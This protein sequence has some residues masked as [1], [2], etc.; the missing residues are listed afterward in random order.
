MQRRSFHYQT[1]DGGPLFS[2]VTFAIYRPKVRY[3]SQICL[4]NREYFF[5]HENAVE[6]DN[7]R[8][9]VLSNIDEIVR[10]WELYRTPLLTEFRQRE[11]TSTLSHIFLEIRTVSLQNCRRRRDKNP[12]FIAAPFYREK[13]GRCAMREENEE[14]TAERFFFPI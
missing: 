9:S 14:T 4:P 6:R 11:N 10:E 2:W 7:I 13:E 3:A 1:W 8:L 12:S 5:C